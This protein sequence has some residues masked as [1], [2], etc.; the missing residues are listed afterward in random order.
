LSPP[1]YDLGLFSPAKLRIDLRNLLADQHTVEEEMEAAAVTA[2]AMMQWL[3]PLSSP[4]RLQQREMMRKIEQLNRQ[5]LRKANL[6][7]NGPTG[8]YPMRAALTGIPASATTSPSVNYM[9]P[10]PSNTGSLPA[11]PAPP[12]SSAPNPQ[13]MQ[14][15]TVSDTR[16]EVVIAKFPSKCATTQSNGEQPVSHRSSEVESRDNNDSALVGP[17]GDGNS[18]CQVVE[19]AI[20]SNNEATDSTSA[21]GDTEAPSSEQ[22][23]PKQPS[24]STEVRE[25]PESSNSVVD[26]NNTNSVH[27]REQPL[28]GRGDDSGRR[29]EFKRGY[30]SAPIHGYSGSKLSNSGGPSSG[31]KGY[32][33]SVRYQVHSRGSRTP[34]YGHSATPFSTANHRTAMYRANRLGSGPGVPPS[35]AA[36]TFNP[37][38]FHASLDFNC[39]FT[40]EEVEELLSQGIRPW[41]SEAAAALAVLHGELDHLLD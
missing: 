26:S 35:R 23:T 19:E 12:L 16:P 30:N 21:A 14:E 1:G 15:M 22:S 9:G 6:G 28:L 13:R 31:F 37:P 18:N 33:D 7:L 8:G 11:T 25:K 32:N 36:N 29:V 38:S 3:A 40:D 20:V 34:C 5:V 27:T 4:W 41:D 2:A 39:G 24:E 17:L 10:N